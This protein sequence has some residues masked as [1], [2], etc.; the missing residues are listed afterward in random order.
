M[1]K[2]LIIVILLVVALGAVVAFG[3]GAL[4][5][6]GVE[7]GGTWALGTK[8]TLDS[9]SIGLGTVGMK[10]LTIASPEGFKQTNAFQVDE[11]AVKA[12]LG[13]LMTDTIEID[14]I[15]I[16]KPEIGLEF[17]MNGTN[18]GALLK[19]LESRRTGKEPETKP[20]EEGEKPGKALHVGRVT[21]TTPRVKLAQSA[22]LATSQTIDLPTI[23]LTDLGGSG[24]K[25]DGK[26]KMGLP[27]L[28]EQI[29]GA[30]MAATAQSGQLSGDLGK[31]LNGDIA[32]DF[33]KNVKG[34]VGKLGDQLKKQAQGTLEDAKDKA[35]DAVDEAKKKAE[36]LKNKGLGGLLG[37]DKK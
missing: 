15:D 9:A 18:I 23:E 32:A 8:T 12:Q 29:L 7:K 25:E 4:L 36:E 14:S 2:L 17:T 27:E 26:T 16:V 1:K 35:K 21:I 22:L 24:G 11:I 5:K 3:G 28:I 6:T 13:S 19:N 31:I 20:A 30:I 10:D 37:G 34:D 33:L